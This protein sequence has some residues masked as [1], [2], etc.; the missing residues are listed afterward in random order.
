MRQTGA[1]RPHDRIPGRELTSVMFGGPNLDILY[2]T[3]MGKPSVGVVE[4][5]KSHPIQPGK[6]L[7]PGDPGL[8]GLFAV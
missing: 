2:V 5:V 1:R 7:H 6:S 8:G 3:T 4:Y